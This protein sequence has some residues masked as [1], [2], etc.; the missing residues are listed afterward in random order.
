MQTETVSGYSSAYILSWC[1]QRKKLKI[2][3]PPF[4]SIICLKSTVWCFPQCVSFEKILIRSIPYICGILNPYLWRPWF[5]V[6]SLELA[7]SLNTPLHWLMQAKPLPATKREKRL[8]ERK[9]LNPLLKIRCCYRT[10]DSAMAA[11]QNGF[12]SHKLAIHKNQYYT[13][14]DKKY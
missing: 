11:S 3:F 6:H 4:F 1:L 12:C 7:P 8:R 10:V 13:D 9:I 2:A 14:Y 5:E